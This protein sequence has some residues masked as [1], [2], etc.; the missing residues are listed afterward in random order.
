MCSP[1]SFI[2]QLIPRPIIFFCRSWWVLFILR[3][4]IVLSCVK[5]GEVIA[6]DILALRTPLFFKTF[7][8]FTTLM[9]VQSRGWPFVLTFWSIS[10]FCFLYGSH[11]VS[12]SETMVPAL[13][14]FKCNLIIFSCCKTVCKTLAF[15]AITNESVQR[16]Q[17]FW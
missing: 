8:W 7:G 6:I 5:T 13:H 14:C 9:I 4:V 2:K 16:E 12:K 15:L 1:N 11:G 17:P 10:D 3:Q